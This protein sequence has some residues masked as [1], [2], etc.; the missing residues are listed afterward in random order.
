[1]P[2]ITRKK[3]CPSCGLVDFTRKHRTFWMR[4]FASGRLYQCRHCRSRILLLGEADET[5]ATS[6]VKSE[7]YRE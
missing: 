7:N 3:I 4:W 1:M 5:A 2:F 6:D